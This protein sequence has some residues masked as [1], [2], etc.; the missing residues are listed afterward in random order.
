MGRRADEGEDVMPEA[1]RRD[2][3][4]DGQAPPGFERTIAGEILAAVEA[5]PPPRRLPWAASIGGEPRWRSTARRIGRRLDAT[6]LRAAAACRLAA[7]RAWRTAER[8]RRIERATRVGAALEAYLAPLGVVVEADAGIARSLGGAFEFETGRI[9]MRP[10]EWFE[11]QM[12]PMTY[13]EALAHEVIHWTGTPAR[14]DRPTPRPFHESYAFEEVVAEIGQCLLHA[15]L[16]LTPSVDRSAAYVARWLPMVRGEHDLGPPQE[17]RAFSTRSVLGPP[18][19][20]R[21]IVVRA[22]AEAERAVEF[23]TD[24]C[25]TRITLA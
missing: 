14:L 10:V 21:S 22:G 5:G 13:P 1:Q 9:R 3:V 18:M 8:R 16:G 23:I 7:R 25:G 11:D 24:R 20:D 2:A 6:G 15:T 12:S 19:D 17:R 4:G